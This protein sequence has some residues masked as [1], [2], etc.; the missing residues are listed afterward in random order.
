MATQTRDF[1]SGY[2]TVLVQDDEP[3]G[4]ILAP[5]EFSMDISD[6]KGDNE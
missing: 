1:T 6:M 5:Q 4:E 3:L 2:V